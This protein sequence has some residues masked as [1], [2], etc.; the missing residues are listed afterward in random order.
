MPTPTQNLAQHAVA[1]KIYRQ[2]RAVLNAEGIEHLVLKGPHLASVAY[3]K[4]WERGFNDLDLLVRAG[5]FERAVDALVDSGFSR[6]EPP[7]G[8]Q[9]TIAAAYDRN[10][11]APDGSVVEVHR[12]FAPYRLY[13][14][15][16]DAL[17]ERAVDFR[18]GGTPARGLSAADLLVHLVIHAAKSQFALIESKHVRDVAAVVN[19]MALDW[20]L[21]REQTARA[22]CRSAAWVLL[23]AGARAQGA[24][25][26][27]EILSALRPGPVRR[28]WIDRWIARNRFPMLRRTRFPKPLRRILLAPVLADRIGQVLRAAVRF[29]GVRGKDWVNG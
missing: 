23:G 28:W 17:F 13:P 19:S 18:F 11:L 24:A 3:E 6:R 20:P 1:E 15:D 26:P 7:R 29:A 5:E 12:A 22:G 2:V 8:R 25:V 9:A 16:Y 21:F 27:D 10:L 4:P 14:L